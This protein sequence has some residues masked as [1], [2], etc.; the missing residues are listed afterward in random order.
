ME[1]CRAQ[2]TSRWWG[3]CSCRLVL[4]RCCAVALSWQC[5]R[6]FLLQFQNVP[7]VRYAEDIASITHVFLF[8]DVCICSSLLYNLH[9]VCKNLPLSVLPV[10][11]ILARYICQLSLDNLSCQLGKPVEPTL[12][13]VFVPR[14]HHFVVPYWHEIS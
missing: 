7:D 10:L 3:C 5:Q 13:S 11:T 6:Q 12:L 1:I 4:V 2:C 14:S 9:C 8:V